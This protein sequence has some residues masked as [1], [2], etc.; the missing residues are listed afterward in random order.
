[1]A[2]ENIP[3]ANFVI[4]TFDDV[5]RAIAY[6]HKHHANAV[7]DGKPLVVSIDQKQQDRSKA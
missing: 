6:M 3:P 2:A 1:M 4:N 5:G 7:N